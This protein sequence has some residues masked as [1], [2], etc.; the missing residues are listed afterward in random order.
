LDAAGLR[1]VHETFE[2]TIAAGDKAIAYF[3]GYLFAANPQLR[4]MFP[5]CLNE[6]RDRLF[7]ALTRI[8]QA[9]GDRAELAAYL[10][11]LGRDHRKYL[12]EYQHY[13]AVGDALV[14]TLRKFSR[15]AWTPAAHRAW[16]AA[17]QQAVGLMTAAADAELAP[18][19]WT[20]E[21]V[22]HELRGDDLAVLTVRTY[23][24]L[25]YQAGQ[26]VTIQHPRW[27]RVW[28]PYSV[29]CAPRDDGLLIFHVKAVP[30]GWVSN[31]LVRHTRAGDQLVVG[32]AVG[33]MTLNRP[34]GGL[35]CIAGGTGLAPLKAIIEC[36]ILDPAAAG[37][38][39]IWLF[40]GARREAGLYDLPAMLQLAAAYPRLHIYP[41][42]SDDPAYRGLCGLVPHVA[43]GRIPQEVVDAYVAGPPGMVAAAV[44]ALGGAGLQSA[45][46]YH[47]LAVAPAGPGGSPSACADV[48]Q[49]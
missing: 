8:V 13:E 41:V 23:G 44:H 38:P 18:P 36:V 49:G 7:G 39:D 47:D 14:A 33:T 5:A 32:P 16:A 17:Y 22:Y 21:V 42:V 3:Y 27:H 20:G 10:G 45:R 24:P 15:D 37:S 1:A 43:A 35:L 4:Q 40:Y 46:V 11:Q 29:A 26:R 31:A 28:R 25:P 30:G 2:A 34:R 9:L 19:R 6:Q 12:V 48:R